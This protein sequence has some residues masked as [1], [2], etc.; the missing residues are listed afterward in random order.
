[1]MG[2]FPW[3]G[4]GEMGGMGKMFTLCYSKELHTYTSAWMRLHTLYHLLLFLLQYTH[5]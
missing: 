5:K 1:M 2:M 3:R 4:G